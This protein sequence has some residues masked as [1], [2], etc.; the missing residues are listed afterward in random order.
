MYTKVNTGT[1]KEE[2]KQRQN[3]TKNESLSVSCATFQ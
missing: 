3:L 1:S 2:V